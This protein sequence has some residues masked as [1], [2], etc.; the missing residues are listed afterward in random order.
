MI[1][2]NKL[3]L[4]LK[5]RREIY[6]YIKKFP[7]THL[8]KISEDLNLSLSIVRYHT[9]YMEKKGLLT[10]EEDR[11]YKRFFCKNKLDKNQRNIAS[12]LRQKKFREI[13]LFLLQYPD[14]KHS[15][16]ASH[17][18]L[19]LSTL[20]K[21][22]EHLMKN[23]IVEESK[24]GRIKRY[25]VIKEEDVVKFLITYRESFSDKLVDNILEIYF[26]R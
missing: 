21:Y 8:R 6:N 4:D 7:G 16:I 11:Y 18:N 15:E 19:P 24:E 17:L 20:T 5:N 10:N 1:E 12:I 9:H 23:E 2:E 25:N 13:V 3:I 14:S 26:E 22:M